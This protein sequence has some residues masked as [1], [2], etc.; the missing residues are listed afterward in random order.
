[1]TMRPERPSHAKRNLALLATALLFVWAAVSVGVDPAEILE[2]PAGLA[3]VFYE[4][5]LGRHGHR[6][7]PFAA[8]RLLWREERVERRGLERHAPDPQRHPGIS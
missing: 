7:D 6:R 3:L 8:S 2:L 5:F 4:M 1:M